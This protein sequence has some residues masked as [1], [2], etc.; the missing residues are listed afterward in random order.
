M[1][2]I[3]NWTGP[4][5]AFT[6]YNQN[7]L[8]SFQGSTWISTFTTAGSPPIPNIGNT[9]GT[10]GA[11]VIFVQMGT[12]GTPGATGAPGSYQ[13]KGAWQPTTLYVPGNIVYYQGTAYVCNVAAPL[14]DAPTDATYWQIVIPQGISGNPGIQGPQGPGFT[15]R[16][17]WLLTGSYHVN[18][19]V[20]F[21]GNSYVAITATTGVNPSTDNGTNW[22]VMAMGSS[23]ILGPTLTALRPAASSV[24]PGTQYY[25]LNI[26]LPLWSDGQFWRDALGGIH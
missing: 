26:H 24:P 19:V 13:F 12:P 8:V 20:G 9:P 3:P 23:A 17:A 14:A 6:A 10:N 25:D 16:G 11:W 4:W 7:D 15:W 21:L 2:N 18:D 1:A 5:N 22:Q